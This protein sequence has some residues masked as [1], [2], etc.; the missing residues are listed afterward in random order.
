MAI[1]DRLRYSVNMLRFP[2]IQG[3]IFDL[4][5]TLLDNGPADQPEV[6]L[7]SRSRLAAVHEVGNEHDIQALREVTQAENGR[8]FVT[9][10][11]HS[12]QG[13]IWNIF[14]M[15]GL[16]PTNEF[17][18]KSP[19]FSLVDEIADR[20]NQL[21]ESIIMQHGKEVAGASQFIQRLA[22]N[23]ITKLALATNAIQRDID[24]FLDKYDLRQYFPEERIISFEKTSKPKPD[25]ESFDL[26]F[27]SLGLP[28]SARPYVAGFEDNP[29][30]IQSIKAAG[31]YACAIT[32]RLSAKDLAELPVKPD[33]IAESYDEFG[34]L[35][36]VPA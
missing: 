8:A 29:R 12:L 10:P 13:A 6:W 21:H 4:D 22:A 14:F 35:L 9:S 18:P 2:E 17:D 25:P 31:L 27:Q 23:G 5:D 30:G 19:Y 3:V 32:T 1:H 7:H 34:R 28:E 16:V 20:K 24:V 36:Q 33:L 15:K 26:A 11:V